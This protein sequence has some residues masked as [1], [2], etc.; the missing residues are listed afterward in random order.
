MTKKILSFLAY[1]NPKY[2]EFNAENKSVE[3]IRKKC[4][5]KKLFAK[6]FGKVL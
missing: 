1:Q 2:A 3:I 5:Q 4:N 6:N